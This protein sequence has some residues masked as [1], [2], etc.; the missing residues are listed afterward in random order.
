MEGFERRKLFADADE[1]DRRSR[2][3]MNRERGAAARVAVDLRQDHARDAE[4]LVE[5]FGDVGRLLSGHRVGDE[6]DFLRIDRRFHALELVHERGVDLQTARRIDDHRRNT[7]P[8]RLGDAVARDFDRILSVADED[9][10]I[11]LLAECLQLIDCCR[12]GRRRRPPT[13]TAAS[14]FL[15]TQRQLSGLRRFSGTLQT[16]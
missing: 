6:K 11:D 15:Q 3:G 12:A 5:S 16:D 9:R 10:E 14:L 8:A 2:F 1:L 4:T 7:E 13:A